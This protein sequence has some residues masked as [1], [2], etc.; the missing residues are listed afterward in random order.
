MTRTSFGF[1]PFIRCLCNGGGAAN[2]RIDRPELFECRIEC[3]R[4]LVFFVILVALSW[5]A[6]LVW[7]RLPGLL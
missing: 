3:L 6:R 5:P 2:R 7:R 4:G 1:F